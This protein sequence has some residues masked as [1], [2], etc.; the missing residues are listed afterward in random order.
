MSLDGHDKLCGYQKSVF[1]L[2][3]YGGQDTYSGRINFLKIWTTNN[4]PKVIGRFYYN[5]LQ[6]NRGMYLCKTVNI[7]SSRQPSIDVRSAYIMPL[8]KN[9]LKYNLGNML[10]KRYNHGLY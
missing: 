1:P 3:I 7:D 5:Y 10:D 2:C 4:D 6:E 8:L 9:E